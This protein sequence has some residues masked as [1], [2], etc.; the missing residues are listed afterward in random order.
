M[1]EK[2]HPAIKAYIFHIMWLDTFR[3]PPIYTNNSNCGP[4]LLWIPLQVYVMISFPSGG[5]RT[6]IFQRNALDLDFVLIYKHLLLKNSQD[7]K[8]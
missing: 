2:K 1:W 5:S 4:Y 3:T 7:I 8:Y 6:Y